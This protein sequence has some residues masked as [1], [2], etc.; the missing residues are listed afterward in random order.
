MGRSSAEISRENRGH[1]LRSL[2]EEMIAECAAAL[3]RGDV[4][5]PEK[6]PRAFGSEAEARAAFQRHAESGLGSI[7]ARA[8]LQ[9]RMRG[10]D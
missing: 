8:E 10:D 2:K 7:L 1:E 9:R 4:G 6:D 3:E 5:F